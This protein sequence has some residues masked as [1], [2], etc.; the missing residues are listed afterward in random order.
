[1]A[2]DPSVAVAL[3]ACSDYQR[4]GIRFLLAGE[5]LESRNHLDWGGY[6]LAA[7]T[8]L[9]YRFSKAA[10][11]HKP[12]ES[13]MRELQLYDPT[14]KSD[15]SEWLSKRFGIQIHDWTADH[16]AKAL[17][18]LEN[19]CRQSPSLF[20]LKSFMRVSSRVCR[21]SG[22]V[23]I[24]GPE[25]LLQASEALRPVFGDLF[26]RRYE[27]AQAWRPSHLKNL[28]SSTMILV[29]DL[30]ATWKRLIPADCRFDARGLDSATSISRELAIILAER[31]TR[32]EP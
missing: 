15:C 11:K 18:T 12:V 23:V 16:V 19:R 24:I 20:S 5:L 27:E 4:N 25:R 10:A 3:D 29:P 26:F 14:A 9:A 6:S 17:R 31:C 28:V 2:E 21:P 30:P 7:G 13:S 1:M 32:R 22:M 8:E